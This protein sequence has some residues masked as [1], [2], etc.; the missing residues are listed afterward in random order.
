MT[1]VNVDSTLAR[2][3]RNALSSLI[4][5]LDAELAPEGKKCIVCCGHG[6]ISVLEN[7]RLLAYGSS[8]R[9]GPGK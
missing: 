1:S 9:Y 5:E 2:D 8:E 3:E 6:S 7:G 4:S